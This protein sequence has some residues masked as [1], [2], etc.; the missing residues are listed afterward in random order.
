MGNKRDQS[1][2]DWDVIVIGSG[3]GGMAAAAA[4]SKTG[5]RV[6]LL[7]QYH[8]LGGLTHSFSRD[9]FSWDVGIHSWAN[10]P[11]ATQ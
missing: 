7:E 9:G 11:L 3:I 5:Y 6:L 8:T 1:K 4:L 2:N 10:S